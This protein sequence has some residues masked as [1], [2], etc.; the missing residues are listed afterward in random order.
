MVTGLLELFA[1]QIKEMDN[2]C[3]SKRIIKQN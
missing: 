3:W 1:T 2:R